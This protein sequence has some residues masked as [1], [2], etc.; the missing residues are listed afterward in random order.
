MKDLDK[1][2]KLITN[3]PREFWSVLVFLVGDLGMSETESFMATLSIFGEQNV[4][5]QVIHADLIVTEK[6]ID[7]NEYRVD[8]PYT[9]KV[10]VAP[11]APTNVIGFLR[12]ANKKHRVGGYGFQADYI[13]FQTTDSNIATFLRKCYQ[14]EFKIEFPSDEEKKFHRSLEKLIRR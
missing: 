2:E 3:R 14:E 5:K 4:F 13:Q 1:I 10:M 8:G 7:R 11:D 9:F 12:I 6:K